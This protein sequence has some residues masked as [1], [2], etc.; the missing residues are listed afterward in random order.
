[1]G[2][3]CHP[4]WIPPLVTQLPVE[5]YV[6]WNRHRSLERDNRPVEVLRGECVISGGELLLSSICELVDYLL[7]KAIMWSYALI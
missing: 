5:P 6:I 4:D 1:M 3:Q 2:S 7:K